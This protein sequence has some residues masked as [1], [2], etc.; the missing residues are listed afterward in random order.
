MGFEVSYVVNFDELA[1]L[2]NPNPD[3][4]TPIELQPII[5]LLK[6]LKDGLLIPGGIQQ[7]K[8][9]AL[10]VPA[11]TGD[12]IIPWVPSK[13]ILITGVTYG[14]SAWKY[15]DYWD[16][17]VHSVIRL[18]ESVYTKELNEYKDFKKFFPVPAGTS[19]NCILHNISGNSRMV[20]VDIHYLSLAPP[21][22]VIDDGSIPVTT[23]TIYL[24]IWDS[25]VEDNDTID[26]HLNGAL[27]ES[28]FIAT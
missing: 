18:F 17:E 27:V 21:P 24:K 19:I 23:S 12:F 15:Q 1:A 28:N 22:P 4:I 14:Q 10:H 20:W 9:L 5:D 6:D 25:S 26:I 13:D 2:L 8:G 16:L 11:L 7:I 3:P